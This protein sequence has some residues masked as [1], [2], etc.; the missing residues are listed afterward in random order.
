MA[1]AIIGA[2]RTLRPELQLAFTHFSPSAERLAQ[3]IGADVHAYLPWDMRADMRRT[4]A[5]LQPT[6]I[7]FVRTEVWPVLTHEAGTAGARLALV[8][9]VLAAES[10]RLRPTSRMLLGPAY[11]RLDGVGAV[12]A[13]D[14]AR[15]PRLGVAASRVRVTGD[16]R[17][18]Q[19]IARVDALDRHGPRLLRLHDAAA[20]T[21]VAGST[22]PPDEERLVPA[23]ARARAEA[24]LRLIV[25]PHEPN[26]VHLSGLER[27]LDAHGLAH[28]RLTR[29]ERNADAPPD[30]I[31]IDRIGV[32]ADSYAA[33]DLAYVGGGFHAP[34]VHS[35][36][37]PAALAVPV[38]FGPRH[39]NA[40]EAQELVRA[41]GAFEVGDDDDLER[42]LLELARDE[43][44]RLRT[45][46]AAEAYVR[47]QLGGA[48]QNA[49]LVLEL[50]EP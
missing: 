20:T 41:A 2:L 50:M 29:V 13:D 44:G 25:A 45:G 18:D 24:R 30:V 38:L 8:N 16:A 12:A 32:L 15:F 46:S 22:W 43:A 33:A 39:R 1:R 49:E 21:V 6:A 48:G 17:F 37:E 26:E 5:A 31:V 27:R 3:R 4:L 42:R 47:S 28:A 36:V 34:G 14:A 9:A 23:F 35:V 19:V 10:S 7:A 11:G 40:R